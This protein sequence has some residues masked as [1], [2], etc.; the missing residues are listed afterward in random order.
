MNP[1]PIIAFYEGAKNP[2][3]RTLQQVLSWDDRQLE[4]VHDWVQWVFPNRER[5]KFHPD[6]PL[7]DDEAAAYLSSPEMKAV[8]VSAVSRFERF[9]QIQEE[10]PHWLKRGNHNHLRI[11]RLLKFMMEVGM[12]HDAEVLLKRLE[13][14][15]E[16][17]A[18]LISIFTISLWTSTVR[19]LTGRPM[20]DG[21]AVFGSGGVTI[22][23]SQTGMS[24]WASQSEIS[25]VRT[26][27]FSFDAEKGSNVLV[28]SF[29]E[30][31]DPETALQIEESVRIAR[32][33]PWVVVRT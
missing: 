13:E 3:G 29:Y 23:L 30:S 18:H 5:S 6:A 12:Q 7:M 10:S 9:L 17:N 4:D 8:V 24:V 19:G 28:L 20:D 14:L 25:Y 21:P 26:A 16:D 32:T 15:Y 2:D 22:A 33:I 27:E 1:N 11:T 31:H